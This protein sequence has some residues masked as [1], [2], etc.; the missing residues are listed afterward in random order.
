MK[1]VLFIGVTKF[2]LEKNLHLEKK[3][4]GLSKGIRPYV[5][6]KGG[7]FHQ[8]KWGTEFYLLPPSFFWLLAPFVAFWLCW[9]KKIDVII[10]QSPLLEGLLG[11]FLKIMLKKEFIVE[12]H[13]DWEERLPRFKGV[14]SVFAKLSLK[15]ADKIR[16][17][18]S[19]TKEKAQNI[20]PDKPYFI[21]PTFTDIDIFLAKTDIKFEKFVLFVGNLQKIKG[22]NILLES[23]ALISKELPD[24]SVI[25]VGGGPES[26]KLK[27]Q[28]LNLKLQDK[29]EFKGAL[30]LKEVRDIM[31][32]CYCLV[33][34]SFT[35]GLGRVLM[36][37]MALA[38]PVVASNVGGIPDLV[39]DGQNGFLFEVGNVEQLAEKLRILLKDKNLAVQM[40]QRGRE[41]VQN[42]FSNE[43]YIQNYLQMI[44]Q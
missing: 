1:K 19:F 7:T 34:P 27:S 2:N 8:K 26:S 38:K 44:N 25:L 30:S 4:N 24:F 12:V 35:E 21:F 22:I 37:A 28:T 17:I 32:D 42:K 14:L 6:G 9:I 15:S 18:S 16:A 13:G 36:E 3:F 39:K 33:L 23:F 29:I 11:L 20:S 41:L 40:G 10:S 43:K 5:F 31:K